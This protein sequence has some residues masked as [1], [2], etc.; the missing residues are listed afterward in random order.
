[1]NAQTQRT[2]GCRH[3]APHVLV[4]SAGV[5]GIA[6]GQ[7]LVPYGASL[8]EGGLGVLADLD[9]RGIRGCPDV[10]ENHGC[11]LSCVLVLDVHCLCPY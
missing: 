11:A 3:R 10:R 7:R 1:M 2:E 5:R 9:G 4:V 6:Y 8:G